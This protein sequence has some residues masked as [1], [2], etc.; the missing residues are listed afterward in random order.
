MSKDYI[1][2]D[3]SKYNVLM[4]AV[5][6]PSGDYV[7]SGGYS[8]PDNKPGKPI[9]SVAPRDNGRTRVEFA[10]QLVKHSKYTGL[11]FDEENDYNK[12]ILGENNF[13]YLY[14]QLNDVSDRFIQEMSIPNNNVAYE[15]AVMTVEHLYDTI[16]KAI[17]A[18]SEAE[19]KTLERYKKVSEDNELANMPSEE[20][21]PI[22]KLV[23]F[24]SVD[25]A[26]QAFGRFLEEN[27]SAQK[28]LPNAAKLNNTHYLFTGQTNFDGVRMDKVEIDDSVLR[29]RTQKQI[30]AI[31]SS[32]K[33]GL[34]YSQE[35]N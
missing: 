20:P 14:N 29:K 16:Y 24:G 1:S 19:L 8:F 26:N 25:L 5:F 34:V 18:N 11:V 9:N 30:N 15:V 17:S 35:N 32:L 3:S 28:T 4:Y 2:T 13:F 33:Q 6:T 31:T 12:F 7:S 10:N 22:S 23:V 21:K 27:P